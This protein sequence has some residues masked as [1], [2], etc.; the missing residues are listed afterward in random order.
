M[1]E[2]LAITA[3]ILL[4]VVIGLLAA[5]WLRPAAPGGAAPA[6]LAALSAGQER[7]ERLL[8]DDLATARKESAAQARE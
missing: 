4:L 1:L 8:R 5:L 3:I 6:G 7:L 2:A